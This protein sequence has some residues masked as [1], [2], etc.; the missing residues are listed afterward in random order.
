LS[1][2]EVCD[3]AGGGGIISVWTRGADIGTDSD[4]ERN[5]QRIYTNG[6]GKTKGGGFS[7]LSPQRC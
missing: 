3:I 4:V 6:I 5:V 7:R 2:D 1:K